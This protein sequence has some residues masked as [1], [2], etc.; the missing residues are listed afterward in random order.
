[1]ANELPWM[2]NRKPLLR[3][4]IASDLHYGQPKT[5]YA[6][7]T[8]T[9]LTHIKTMHTEN[10]FAFGVF[11][12]DLVHDNISYFGELRQKIETVPFPYY[13]TQGN[14]DLATKE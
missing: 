8:D 13:V 2:G 9:A 5:E 1:M 3:F 11:N 12:G 14:H 10:P 6:A 7:M 4:V